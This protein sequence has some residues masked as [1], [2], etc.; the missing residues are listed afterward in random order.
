MNQ[1]VDRNGNARIIAL[2]GISGSGKTHLCHQI[3]QQLSEQGV[4]VA[5]IICPPFFE[6]GIKIRIMVRNLRSGR[7]KILAGIE[8]KN[9]V[10]NTGKWYFSDEGWEHGLTAMQQALPCDV[11]IID[12]IG[13]IEIQRSGGWSHAF[14]LLRG[15]QYRKALV[16]I[17]PELLDRFSELVGGAAPVI[18]TA[19]P[20]SRSAALAHICRLVAP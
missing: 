9:S 19:F 4:D 5:G 3:H 10:V 15:D 12:E 11:L 8:K 2:S 17:R 14:D 13:P 6:N 20:D 1:T 18:V 7:E 16:T